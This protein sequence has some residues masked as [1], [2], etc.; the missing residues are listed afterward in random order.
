MIKND[1]KLKQ[2]FPLLKEKIYNKTIV[3]LD[4]AA[5][6][7]LPKCSINAVHKYYL[8]KHANVNKGVHT[9][10]ELATKS[11]E[12]TRKIVQKFINAKYPEECIFVKNTTEAL[13]LIA[14]TVSQTYLKKGDGVLLTDMEHHASILPWR[15]LSTKYGYELY[16]LPVKKKTGVLDIEKLKNILN[17]K[18]IK[19][20][21]IVHVSNVLGTI[22]PVEN[23]I[24]LVQ[25]KNII[26]IVDGAQSVQHLNINVQK[27]NCDFFVFSGHKMYGPTGVGILYGKKNIL[28]NLPP[29]TSGG[30]MVLDITED[31]IIYNDLP[32]KFEAGTPP[33]ASIAGLGETIN[34]LKKHEK[35]I[36]KHEKLLVSYT[37]QKLKTIEGLSLLGNAKNRVG[38]FSFTMSGKH[39][40]DIG[41]LLNQHGIAVRTGHLCTLPLLKKYNTNA[42]TRVSLGMYT[43]YEDINKLHS[44]LLK[45]NKILKNV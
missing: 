36:K 6:S 20:L 21:N 2:Y 12:K 11:M 39:P 22:N 4:T 16:V 17:E 3:Y 18:N 8:K 38:I 42:V 7:Q 23:I 30:N 32:H 24:K 13:N 41:T 34:F 35:K 44:T 27:I 31:T 37:L 5:T 25:K 40:H 15:L 28:E 43:T 10:S 29:Y 26:T 19:V 1:Y 45:I 14:H 33:L 9:L